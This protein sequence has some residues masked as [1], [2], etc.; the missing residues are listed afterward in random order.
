[1]TIAENIYRKWNEN[2][3]LQFR[4]LC[5]HHHTKH[6]YKCDIFTLRF[7]HVYT[8]ADDSSLT[9]GTDLSEHNTKYFCEVKVEVKWKI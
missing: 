6:R 3:F 2:R 8:F 7:E 1:M 4:R 9:V 5:E